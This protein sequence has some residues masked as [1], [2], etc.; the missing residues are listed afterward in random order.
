MF[1]DKA[2]PEELQQLAR[3]DAQLEATKQP[4]FDAINALSKYEVALREKYDLDPQ[5]AILRKA[6]VEAVTQ[7]QQRLE[8]ARAQAKKMLDECGQDPSVQNML[9]VLTGQG[10][11]G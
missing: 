1:F 2:T 10:G 7:E 11:G 4:Y 8:E 5:T 3:L 6:G 9:R